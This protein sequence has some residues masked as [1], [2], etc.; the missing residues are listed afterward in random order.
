MHITAP[1]VLGMLMFLGLIGYAFFIGP[2]LSS[3]V[4]THIPISSVTAP[5]AVEP[6]PSAVP[7]AT[8]VPAAPRVLLRAPLARAE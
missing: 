4:P 5:K 8:P 7:Q 2:W 6:K 1:R 3:T